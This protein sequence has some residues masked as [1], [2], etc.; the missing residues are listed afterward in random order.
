VTVSA[1]DVET[2][3]TVVFIETEDESH[4]LGSS[5]DRAIDW[6]VVRL[7]PQHA[8]ASAAIPIIFP[9][10]RVAGRIYSDGSLRQNTPIAPALKLGAGRVLV[11]GLRTPRP[12]SAPRAGRQ[13]AK[14]Q[15]A[16]SSPLYLF[17]K[18]LDA[19]L[20]D[21]VENDL[22]NLRQ[23]NA[24]LHE[25]ARVSHAMPSSL[26]V[27]LQNA[28]GGLR[29]VADVFIRPS[30]DLASLA[31]HILGRPS[32][33]ARLSGP[34][35]YLLRRLGEAAGRG[36]PSDMLSYLLFDVEYATE[37]LQLGERDA[38]ARKDELEEFLANPAVAPVREAVS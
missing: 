27:A 35:G 2:G 19:L 9:T 3:H 1:T 26:A 8:L 21:R 24:A 23:V 4:R 34:A 18:L 28:G 14:D 33:R 31:E 17:G 36:D 30:H 7:T 11:V 6:T 13:D 16:F 38:A 15:K 5:G 22:A 32:V 25:L 20:L 29:P 12:V 10:V 37:L